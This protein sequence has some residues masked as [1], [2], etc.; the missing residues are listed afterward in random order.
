MRLREPRPSHLIHRDQIPAVQEVQEVAGP[1]DLGFDL[2]AQ[3]HPRPPVKVTAASMVIRN[4][5][6]PA[7]A[8]GP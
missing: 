2:A 8:T 4:A 1:D 3:V 6:R 7:S 5:C